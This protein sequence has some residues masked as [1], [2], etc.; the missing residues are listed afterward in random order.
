MPDKKCPHTSCTYS[1]GDKDVA[2]VV[3]LLKIH[4]L[5]HSAPVDN[6]QK[7]PKL[8]KPKISKG[9]SDEEWN[10]V[11]RKWDIFKKTTTVH[12][13]ELATQL[14][15]CCD[16]E[17]TAELFRDLPNIDS[18]SEVELL[19]CIKRL[20]VLSVS[21]C[22]RKTELFSL[23]LKPR[24]GNPIIRHNCERKGSYLCFR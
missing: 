20:A 8:N 2:I 18:V 21:T 19:A 6:R 16:D 15:Q 22:V 4:A 23:R 13:D 14:W 1:T 9:L 17:L 3:E 12:P 5:S 11:S 10:T 24:S 7:A